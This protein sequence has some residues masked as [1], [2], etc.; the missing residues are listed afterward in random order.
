[1]RKL[2]GIGA[3]VMLGLAG[4]SLG[5][6]ADS[7]SPGASAPPSAQPS[8]NASP[9]PSCADTS[10]E[11]AADAAFDQL[12]DPFGDD[13]EMNAS[14]GWDRHYAD[15]SGYDPCAALSWIGFPLA[16]GTVSSPY[17]IALFVH[18]E[19]EAAPDGSEYG[20]GPTVERLS[21][22]SIEVTYQWPKDGE[23]NAE[24]SGTTVITYTWDE[25]ARE[26]VPSGDVDGGPEFDTP[27]G[28]PTPD[29]PENAYP[30]AGGPAPDGAKAITSVYTPSSSSPEIAMIVTPSGNIGCDFTT[31]PDY[32]PGCG[33]ESYIQ[34][35]PYGGDES[36]NNWWFFFDGGQAT[37][38]TKG[39]APY[40]ITPGTE[41]QEVGYGD[42]VYYKNFVCASEETGLTCWDS[43]TGHGVW[44]SGDASETF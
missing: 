33:V 27:G 31:N 11:E 39:D 19:Y 10:P 16:G 32:G 18:G 40:Y 3:A 43:N 42:V 26:I 37:L 36:G 5:S 4:C 38:G 14:N 9:V 20:W 29:L 23:S 1:M 15:T 44:M 7:P 6:G 24:A 34:D 35:A 41:G 21:D 22:D 28:D 2:W 12:P 30:G 13:E 17:A 25:A 8:P